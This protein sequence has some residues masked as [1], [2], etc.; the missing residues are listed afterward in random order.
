MM[1]E[2][3]KRLDARTRSRLARFLRDLPI[4]LDPDTSVQIWTATQRLAG[5]FRLTV[6][7]AAYLE[8]AHRKNLPL[9]SLDQELHAAGAAIGVKFLGGN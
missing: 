8:L 2:R 7:D 6:Y 4:T 9:A 1:A 3:R 5:R